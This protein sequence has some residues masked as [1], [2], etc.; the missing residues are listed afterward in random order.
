VHVTIA[1]TSSTDLPLV[2][3]LLA[4]QVVATGSGAGGNEATAPG[5]P[6]AEE[7]AGRP[8]LE[9]SFASLDH[10]VASLLGFGTRVEV[11]APPAVRT[12]VG[13]AARAVAALYPEPRAHSVTLAR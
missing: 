5:A 11:L 1:V 10:A 13:D 9:V 7:E 4:G 8:H 3:R 6:R 12:A 2:R